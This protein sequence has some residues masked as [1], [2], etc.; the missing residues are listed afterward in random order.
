MRIDLI[1]AAPVEPA[2]NRHKRVVIS[3]AARKGHAV[4]ARKTSGHDSYFRELL[5]SLYDAAI[6]CDLSGRIV[7]TNLR[8]G[9][10]FLYAHDEFC[11]LAIPDV[12]SGADASLIGTLWENLRNER[13]TLIQ[14]HCVRQDGSQ[15]PAEI[16]VNRLNVGDM[17]LCFFVRDITLRRQAEEMLRTEHSAIQNAGNGI[18]VADLSAA[19]EYVNPAVERMWRCARA[20]ELI[21]TAVRDLF[22][23]QAAAESMIAEVMQTQQAWTGELTAACKDGHAFDVQVSA[24]RNRNSDGDTVGMVFSFVDISDRKR[25]EEAM[26][27]ADRQR[28]M[29]ESFGAACHHLGQPATV[30]M[31]NLDLMHDRLS[32]ASG[33]VRELLDSSIESMRAMGEAL[34]KLIAVDEYRTTTYLRKPLG[35]DG[36]ES[37]IIDI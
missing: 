12:I 32:N 23:N 34:H 27:E 28:V 11:R 31:A 15:F 35:P 36:R 3:T 29:L 16:A 17:R 21:G 24:E 5:Q 18:A 19:L 22:R 30:L 10:F 1:P 26:R 6:I 33:E 13:Y 8:A 37:R 9:D 4:Q 20:N 2:A 25:A 7:D 14:A